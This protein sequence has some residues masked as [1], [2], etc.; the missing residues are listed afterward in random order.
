MPTCSCTTIDGV[1][2]QQRVEHW[3]LISCIADTSSSTSASKISY[4]CMLCSTNAHGSRSSVDS[5][6]DSRV[7]SSLTA[8]SV[9][10]CLADTMHDDVS[11]CRKP[12]LEL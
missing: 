8:A 1:I 10:A 7:R 5:F 9:G 4:P 6:D 11:E 3:S 12:H 2:S